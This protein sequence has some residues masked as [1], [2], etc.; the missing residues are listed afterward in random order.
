MRSSEVS[1]VAEGSKPA[2][3]RTGCGQFPEVP[4]ERGIAVEQFLAKRPELVP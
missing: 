1:S 4:E 2:S 3:G